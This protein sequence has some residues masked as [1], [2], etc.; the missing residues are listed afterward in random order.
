MPPNRSA[1]AAQAGGSQPSAGEPGSRPVR[2]QAG[3]TNCAGAPRSGAQHAAADAENV[4][5]V[6][7]GAG[8][9]PAPV[10]VNAGGAGSGPS[11][12]KLSPEDEQWYNAMG[13]VAGHKANSAL[14]KG[15]D[16]E[17]SPPDDV[18]DEGAGA[19]AAWRGGFMATFKPGSDTS[20]SGV[21]LTAARKRRRS[22]D[23]DEPKG[24]LAGL[25]SAGAKAELSQCVYEHVRL[26]LFLPKDDCKADIKSWFIDKGYTFSDAEYD[27]WWLKS[28]DGGHYQANK[29]GIAARAS[30]VAK[31]KE[32]IWR[33]YSASRHA[34]CVARPIDACTRPQLAGSHWSTM[35]PLTRRS[36]TT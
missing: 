35:T 28:T 6:V 20:P 12:Q 9:L 1:A 24:G 13:R 30:V 19:V 23:P 33:E 11:L 4:A 32:A 36:T 22:S 31:V 2:G 27:T 16:V 7:A 26:F 8:T 17:F 34:R 14:C 25:E 15:D 21:P 5:P 29:K 18:K 3:N 10:G